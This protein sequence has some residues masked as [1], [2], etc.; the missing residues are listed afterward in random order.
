MYLAYAKTE[1][2]QREQQNKPKDMLMG[3]PIDPNMNPL[4]APNN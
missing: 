4:N 2:T 3:T 1:E